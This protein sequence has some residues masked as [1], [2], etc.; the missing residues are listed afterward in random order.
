MPDPMEMIGKEVEVV[1][2][3]GMTYRGKLIEISDVAVHI[4]SQLQY[5]SLPARDV[6]A[7]RL[8]TGTNKQWTDTFDGASSARE[9]TFE[10]PLEEKKP[11]IP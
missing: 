1:S 9:T 8:V 2:N 5:I 3:N 6:T 10:V 4:Q 11:L 7:V